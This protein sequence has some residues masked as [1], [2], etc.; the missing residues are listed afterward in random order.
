MLIFFATNSL[1]GSR[2]NC[3]ISSAQF[4]IQLKFKNTVTKLGIFED[5]FFHTDKVK[6]ANK[7]E[8]SG[9]ILTMLPT[10]KIAMKKM[11]SRRFLIIFNYTFYWVNFLSINNEMKRVQIKKKHNSWSAFV[12]PC[13]IFLLLLLSTEFI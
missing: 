3:L 13:H 12:N 11:C 9:R 7:L 6:T 4:N 2:N 5:F 10:N 8:F 1:I